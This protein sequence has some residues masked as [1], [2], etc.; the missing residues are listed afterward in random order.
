M[1]DR[2]EDD[3]ERLAWVLVRGQASLVTD[4]GEKAVAVATLAST[5]STTQWHWS[6]VTDTGK[7]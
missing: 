7:S 5:S 6:T 1:F 2:Y 3:W 4:K